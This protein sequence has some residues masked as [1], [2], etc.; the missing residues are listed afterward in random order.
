MSPCLEDD[1]MQIVEKFASDLALGG[2]ETD[3]LPVIEN[4]SCRQGDIFSNILEFKWGGETKQSNSDET[5]VKPC[6]G[7]D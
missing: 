6:N 2:D 1:L 5:K 3:A 4:A 7:S